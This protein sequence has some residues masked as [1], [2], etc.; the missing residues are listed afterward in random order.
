[1]TQVFG[2]GNQNFVV[3]FNPPVLFDLSVIIFSGIFQ[4]PSPIYSEPHSPVYSA[5]ESTTSIWLFIKKLNL[6]GTKNF[7]TGWNM[8]T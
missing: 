8:E 6:S 5:P 2:P 1:M 7:V 4:L 3:S